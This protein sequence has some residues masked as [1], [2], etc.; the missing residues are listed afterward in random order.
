MKKRVRRIH[1]LRVE[2]D[3]DGGA[4]AWFN[5]QGTAWEFAK[6]L[7]VI[8]RNHEIYHMQIKGRGASAVI[9]IPPLERPSPL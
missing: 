8:L 1:W 5:F 9:R 7:F 4:G 6:V 2:Y 3:Y